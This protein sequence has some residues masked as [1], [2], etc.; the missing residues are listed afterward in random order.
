MA[1][2]PQQP[3]TGPSTP[4]SPPPPVGPAAAPDPLPPELQSA[5]ASKDE[6]TLAMIAHLLGLAGFLGPL[7]LYLLKKDAASAFVKFHVKQSLFYQ[8]AVAVVLV[9][10]MVLAM[11]GTVLT[12]GLAGCVFFPLIFLAVL[13]D[14]VYLIVAVVQTANGKDFEYY[15]IGPWVR[16]SMM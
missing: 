9:A 4:R 7:V 11:I 14:L 6:R 12:R 1:D 13:G 5:N 2:A 16:R 8:V 10:L 3:Q 15:W